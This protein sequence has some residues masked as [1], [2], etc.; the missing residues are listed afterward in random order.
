V[1]AAIVFPIFALFDMTAPAARRTMVGDKEMA[2][3]HS[4]RS[5]P[6]SRGDGYGA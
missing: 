3:L 4:K 5:V 6:V 2:M 1:L